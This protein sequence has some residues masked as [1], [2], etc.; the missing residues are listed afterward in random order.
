MSKNQSFLNKKR[1]NDNNAF[2]TK[3]NKLNKKKKEDS[4]ILESSKK[5]EINKNE[6]VIQEIQLRTITTISQYFFQKNSENWKD[7]QIPELK[8]YCESI[9]INCESNFKL[10]TELNIQTLNYFLF[11]IPNINLP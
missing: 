4:N 1:N 7:M 10:L 9:E 11:I 2:E 3:Q 6:I 8:K 5:E